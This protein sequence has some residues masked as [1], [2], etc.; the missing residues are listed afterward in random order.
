VDIDP[1]RER[2]PA[3]AAVLWFR[4]DLRLHDQP[5]LLAAASAS[6]VLPV[7]V[8]DPAIWDRAGDQRRR[9]LLRSLGALDEALTSLGGRLVVRRGPPVVVIPQVAREVGAAA[10]HVSADTTPYGRRRD[11]AIGERLASWDIRFIATGSPYV[12]GPGRLASHGGTP[13]RVF[14]PFYRAWQAHEWRAPAEP[15]SPI[16]WLVTDR[17][18]LPTEPTRSGRDW[19]EAGELAA[20]RRWAAFRDGALEGY[21]SQRD[22]PDVDATSQLSVHLKFGE[23]HPRTLLADIAGRTDPGAVGWRRQLAWR[24]FFADQLWHAPASAW[25]PLRADRAGLAYDVGPT[26]DARFAAWV[27]GR[28]GYPF[29][30]AGMRQLA[31]TGWMHNRLRLVTASF[32]TKDL[33]V[34]WRRGARLFMDQLVDGDLASNN[35]SWQWVA[36]TGADT[37]RYSRM[38]NPVTQAR[39]FDP[40]GAYVRRW[41]PELQSVHGPAVH[42]PWAWPGGLPSGY[43]ARIVDHDEE[44]RE[45]LARYERRDR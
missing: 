26:S 25:E 12:V 19:P 30:D 5:A 42:E 38:L 33:H 39:R 24:E 8:L 14:T 20:R 10:V 31:A 6:R 13:Y 23:L 21:A 41:V 1:D 40:D 11:A 15:A 37:A 16:E 34:D 44:R 2:G 27:A 43:P 7:F 32:L 22:R 36:G 45:A 28:T 4:R 3:G 17:E 9:Y 29:V 35:H 18:A